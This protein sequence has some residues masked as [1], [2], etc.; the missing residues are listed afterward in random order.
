MAK[1][2]S[3]RKTNAIILGVTLTLVMVLLGGVIAAVVTETNP[4]DWF[5]KTEYTAPEYSDYGEDSVKEYNKL[6]IDTTEEGEKQILALFD[7]MSE[8]SLSE[9]HIAS[10]G[11]LKKADNY[12]EFDSGYKLVA[13]SAVLED[14]NGTEHEFSCLMLVDTD[15]SFTAII[16]C[17]EEVSVG[18]VEATKGFQNLGENGL[19]EVDDE[20]IAGAVGNGQIDIEDYNIISINPVK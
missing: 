8:N 10:I 15:S 2:M 12:M 19:L 11:N 16:Y 13:N 7:Y 4:T 6:Y 17:T 18:N 20:P 5:V 9:C 14:D 1:K 3:K